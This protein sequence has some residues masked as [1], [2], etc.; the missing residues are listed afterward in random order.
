[1]FL[2]VCVFVFVS[3]YDFVCV[4]VH[5]RESMCVCEGY[6]ERERAR[7]CVKDQRQFDKWVLQNPLKLTRCCLKSC[8]DRQKNNLSNFKTD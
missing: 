4:N 7:V 1:M 5:E 6:K 2:C 8:E 3:V